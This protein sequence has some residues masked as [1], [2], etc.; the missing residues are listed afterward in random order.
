MPFF[1]MYIQVHSKKLG[2]QEDTNQEGMF[3]EV[4]CVAMYV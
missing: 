4:Q 2:H 3:T 1:H